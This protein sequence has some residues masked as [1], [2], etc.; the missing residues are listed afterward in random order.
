MYCID[1]G[2]TRAELPEG[3]CPECGRWFSP[4]VPRTFLSS[5][6][7]YWTKKR[8]RLL[9]GLSVLAAIGIAVVLAPLPYARCLELDVNSGAQRTVH[10]VFGISV[11][12]L[13][14]PTE[15]SEF[16]ERHLAPLDRPVWIVGHRSTPFDSARV[17]YRG[18]G[19]S[20]SLH[21]LMT[22]L[23]YGHTPLEARK[24]LAQV[25]IEIMRAGGFLMAYGDEDG[26]VIEDGTGVVAQW[27]APVDERM[28]R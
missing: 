27:Q 7:R 22:C 4:G 21:S 13:R 14:Q 28:R 18:G 25:A 26:V 10:Q 2:Y 19:Y 8:K 11:L 5:P 23:E 6:R 9:F 15:F 1:C 17:N 3:R 12:S 24:E 20:A 16:A